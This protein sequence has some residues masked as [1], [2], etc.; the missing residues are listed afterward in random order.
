MANTRQGTRRV[1]NVQTHKTSQYIQINISTQ[2]TRHIM[3]CADVPVR[4]LR[5]LLS[6]VHLQALVTGSP[7]PDVVAVFLQHVRHLREH[8]VYNYLVFLR[9]ISVRQLRLLQFQAPCTPHFLR[10]VSVFFV[11][12]QPFAQPANLVVRRRVGFRGLDDHRS[13]GEGHSTL[14]FFV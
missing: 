13:G 11:S 10:D 2:Y 12:V 9:C 3:L 14:A 8:F 4:T 5:N 7:G 6:C 1:M